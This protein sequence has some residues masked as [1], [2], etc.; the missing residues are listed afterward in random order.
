MRFPHTIKFRDQKA[1]IYGKSASYPFYR[2]AFRADGKRFLRSFGT[3]AEAKEEAEKKLRQIHKGDSSASLTPQ[4]SAAAIAIRQ[5][6]DTHRRS[7]GET[8]TPLEAVSSHL[9]AAKLLPK[10][11]TLLEAVRVFART[12]AKVKPCPLAEAVAEFLKSRKQTT[13]AGERPRFSPVYARNVAA[14]LSDFAQTF[15]GHQVAD[16]TPDFLERFLARFSELGAKSRNDRRVAVGMFLRWAARKDYL[17]KHHAEKLLTSDAARAEVLSDTRREFYTPAELRLILDATADSLRAVT[18]IEAFAGARLQ[19]ALRLNWEDL[20]RTPGH[21]EISGKHA[22]T[23]QRRLLEV[24][25]VLA[26]WLKPFKGRKGPIWAAPLNSF[27]TEWARVRE[28]VGVPSKRNGLRHG[29]VSFSYALREEAETAALA[30]TSPA[31]LHRNYRG[32]ATK[33]EAEKWFAVAPPQ[34]AANVIPL[35]QATA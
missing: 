24:G 6:L 29:F 17:D 2:L 7:T 27:I 25:P 23:R 26:Q 14:W 35:S 33:A 10:G 22:K 16:L 18:A 28:S 11:S 30:G 12:L 21:I 5:A 1:V 4:E 19:E 15:P 9:E 13:K 32:L 31:I 3:F 34:E 8:V 20:H